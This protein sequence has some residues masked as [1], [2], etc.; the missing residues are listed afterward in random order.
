MEFLVGA[1]LALSVGLSATFVGL[2][3]D[4]AFYPVVTIV[5][6]SYYALFAAVGG[7]APAL[8]IE[9]IVIVAFV[10][11]AIAG[12]R[13]D[14]K[15]RGT[16]LVARVLPRMRCRGCGLPCVASVAIATSCHCNLTIGC[17]RRTRSASAWLN[18]GIRC[19]AYDP[20][21]QGT[22]QWISRTRGKE[23]H[24]DS[25]SRDSDEGSRRG[26]CRIRRC[27]FRRLRQSR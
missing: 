10:G 7:S 15:S 17:S 6:A 25:V 16:R 12:F 1:V 22:A 18:S 9:S 5:I 13:L 21:R 2:D 19:R 8:A 20:G 26:V 4:R 14:R 3:R 27:T 11:A 23:N 24:A